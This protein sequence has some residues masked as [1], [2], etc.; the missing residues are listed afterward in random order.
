MKKYLLPLALLAGLGT[1][2]AAVQPRWIQADFNG[3]GR[4]DLIATSN[5][6]DVV[7]N[8]EGEVIGWYPKLAAG[9]NVIQQKNGRLSFDR[10]KKSINLVQGGKS[11][12][13][14]IPGNS[15]PKT[16][17]TFTESAD[18]AQNR[19]EATFRYTQGGATVQKTVVLH[20][21]QFNV[22]VTTSVQGADSYTLNFHGLR[23]SA[24]PLVKAV[25]AGSATV[26]SAGTV[27]NIR[28]AGLQERPGLLNSQSATA[29]LVRPL[30]G[31]TANVSLQGGQ[32]A[33]L[34]VQ[35]PGNQASQLEVYGG[36]NELIHLYQGNWASLPGLFSP[37]IFGQLSLL[38]AKLMQWLYSFL[39]NWGLVIVGITILI[40]A[41]IW[42]LMQSQARYTARMQMVQPE[43]KAINEK[44]KDEPQK[45]AEATMALYKEHKV[46]PAGCLPIFIQ[47]PFLLVL[48]GTIRNFE[49]DQG[50]FW[51]PD[52]SV[53]DPL[54]IL[55]ALYVAAN[56]ASLYVTTRK[57]PEMF[58]QQ[59]FMY[60]IF[61]YFALTFPAGVTLYW[62]LGTLF[63]ILQQVLINRQ[64]AHAA[65]A[66]VQ[67][68]APA[69]GAP[70]VKAQAA[71][72]QAGKTQV[73][74]AQPAKPQNPKA[75]PKGNLPKGGRQK[76]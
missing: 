1:A 50:L 59:A 57:T 43:L 2:S 66:N 42:P 76:E 46:N 28:Y 51:V 16:G 10:L 48:Y 17:A 37:N 24:D 60:L 71:N 56:L 27:Q 54:Y 40:R 33:R 26:Q 53:P 62:I 7:F 15:A 11:L 22:D 44:Y 9:T 6:S 61:A 14:L 5:L 18:I 45:R 70:S 30:D 67:R 52:L 20:P 32:N 75:L 12:E 23:G 21:R 34:S 72:T 47:F 3:D 68:V 64:L 58:R 13:V 55:A 38:V 25:A 19:L 39:G 35:L 36:K 63:T 69:G 74:K 8:P 49:F 73:I 4:Q 65:P 29:L 31:T 41:L